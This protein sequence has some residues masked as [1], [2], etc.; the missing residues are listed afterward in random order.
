MEKIKVQV[1]SY[2]Y[3][4]GESYENLRDVEFI[5]EKL[6]SASLY[7]D[8]HGSRGTKYT[9]YK[10]EKGRYLVHEHN[11]SQWKDEPSHLY[12]FDVPLEDLDIDGEYEFLGRKAGLQRALSLDEYL[13]RNKLQ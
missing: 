10:D 2:Y 11:W 8:E 1:G 7:S 12:L 4:I 5:G 3:S 9:L 13:E 6:A